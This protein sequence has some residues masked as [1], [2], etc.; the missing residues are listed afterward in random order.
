MFDV[1]VENAEGSY[2][3]EVYYSVD[4]DTF[5]LITSGTSALPLFSSEFTAVEESEN[6]K[7]N[8]VIIE[9]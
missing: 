5:E 1:N 4:G 2:E 7:V 3:Y 9:I 8:K 6:Y